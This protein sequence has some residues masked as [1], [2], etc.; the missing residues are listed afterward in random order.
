MFVARYDISGGAEWVMGLGGTG[1]DYSYAAIADSS[2]NVV[3]VG[4]FQEQVDFGGTILTSAGGYDG[5][6]AKFDDAGSLLWVT[7]FGASG[8][9]FAK[10]AAVGSND[11]VWVAGEVFLDTASAGQDVFVSKYTSSGS[12]EWVLTFGASGD[13]TVTGLADSGDG[14]VLVT[15]E[16]RDSITIQGTTLTSVGSDDVYLAKFDSNGLLA[17]A[18]SFGGTSADSSRGLASDEAGNVYWS[19]S[20]LGTASVGE[21][22]LS[23]AGNAD[24]FVVKYDE[25]GTLGWA[26]SFGGATRPTTATPS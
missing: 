21:S 8:D 26:K 11:S 3:L 1:R 20:F 16:F 18:K 24:A 2:D 10:F 23:N 19:G 13:E 6:V 22:T 14:G 7:A 17:W 12:F 5:F 25:N 4:Y 15:G 9:D